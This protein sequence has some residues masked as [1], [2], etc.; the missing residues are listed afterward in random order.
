MASAA[1]P[2][3]SAAPPPA[4]A[5]VPPEA[6]A[7]PGW[8]LPAWAWLGLMLILAAGLR[9]YHLRPAGFHLCDEGYYLLEPVLLHVLPQPQPVLYYH[10]GLAVW[11]WLGCQVFGFTYDGALHW[12]VT[13]GLLTLVVYAVAVGRLLGR[14]AGLGGAF[15][16][17]VSSYVLFYHRSNLALSHGLLFL[18]TACLLS[19]ALFA[20]LGVLPLTATGPAPARP[21]RSGR[22]WLLLVALGVLWGYSY[23]LRV[24]TSIIILGVIGALGVALAATQWRHGWSARPWVLYAGA[25][26]ALALLA[27]LT[28]L[29]FARV[30]APWT[31]PALS[32][33]VT[34]VHVGFMR[35]HLPAG[36][37]TSLRTLWH[38]CS[39]PFLALAAGG[40]LLETQRWRTLPLPRV[41]WLAA[42]WGFL[43][44]STVM[45]TPYPRGFVY[46]V[47]F[48]AAYV[49]VA[50]AALAALLPNPRRRAT[51][52]ALMLALLLTGEL[53]LA[54]PLFAARSYYRDIVAFMRA[55]GEAHMVHTSAWPLFRAALPNQKQYLLSDV[56]AAG[57]TYE[58]FC[59]QLAMLRATRGV[60]YLVLDSSIL[61]QAGPQPMLEQFV[62]A[63]RPH[64]VYPDEYAG[65]FHTQAEAFGA[66]LPMRSLLRDWIIVYDLSRLPGFARTPPP[67]TTPADMQERFEAALSLPPRRPQPLPAGAAPR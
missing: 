22:A 62:L 46:A 13:C 25:V 66:F 35:L 29:A 12:S 23:D 61:F 55:S 17:A 31:N 37:P 19:V 38:L 58:S 49:G 3:T 41:W 45:S 51:L 47:F 65:H 54:M 24:D 20:A 7:S 52:T 57:P 56:L 42:T 5:A 14:A 43:A 8:R 50:V 64:L 16:L 59:V 21:W 28:H 32:A 4:P 67:Y 9:L 11:V 27:G 6:P 26:V 33:G 40:L 48:L 44:V 60:R 36:V 10:H 15:A 1:P 2:A 30:T 34:E 18:A 53:V 63:H 39:V